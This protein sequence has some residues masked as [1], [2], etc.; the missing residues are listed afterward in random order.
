MISQRGVT[1][2]AVPLD[3]GTGRRLPMPHITLHLRVG[4]RL[5]I[6]RVRHTH[7]GGRTEMHPRALR[8]RPA[9]TLHVTLRKGHTGGQSAKGRNRDAHARVDGEGLCHRLALC[10][11]IRA[12]LVQTRRV[13]HSKTDTHRDGVLGSHGKVVVDVA[14][15]SLVLLLKTL[16]VERI[17]L[18]RIG[19]DGDVLDTQGRD[20]GPCHEEI[21]AVEGVAGGALDTEEQASRRLVRLGGGVVLYVRWAP[22]YMAR[23]AQCIMDIL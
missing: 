20:L 22:Y 5:R 8:V 6:E 17:Q 18:T 15:H 2:V 11:G 3:L 19:G 12:R 1:Y 9:D 13:G 23:L 16:V 7:G 21:K 10:K 14:T 4:H